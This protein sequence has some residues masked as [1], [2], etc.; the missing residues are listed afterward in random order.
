MKIF[1]KI[2]LIRENEHTKSVIIRLNN[3]ILL[4]QIYAID[5]ITFEPVVQLYSLK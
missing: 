5:R 2:C 4:H 1:S 3:S